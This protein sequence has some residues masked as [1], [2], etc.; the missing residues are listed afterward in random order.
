MK[1]LSFSADGSLTGVDSAPLPKKRGMH[2][3]PTQIRRATDAPPPEKEILR[4]SQD[5]DFLQQEEETLDVYEDSFWSLHKKD[6]TLLEPLPFSN[7]KTQRDVV[8]Q[9]VEHIQHG[10]KVI[11]IHGVCGTGKS[12]IALNIARALNGKAGIVVPI[13]TLQKQYEHDYVHNTFVRKL[14]GQKMKIAMITGRDNHDSIIEPGVSCADPN[15]PDTIKLTDRNMEKLKDY[16]LKNPFTNSKN[17]PSLKHM[18]RISV[19]PANPHWSPIMPAEIELNVLKDATKRKYMGMYGREFVFYHRKPGC[20]YYD[21]YLAY[22][23]AD[24]IIYNAAKYLAESA[25]GR[26][27]QTTVDI[28]DEADEFLDSLSNQKALNLTRLD[29]ALRM[30]VPDSEQ[31]KESIRKI[32][33]FIDAQLTRVRAL[34]IDE[35]Q[36]VPIHETP[37]IEILELVNDDSELQSEIAIDE[38]NYANNLVEAAENFKDALRDTYCLFRKDDQNVFAELVTTNLAQKFNTLVDGN[39]AL[40]LMSGTLHSPAVLEHIFGIE[41][42]TIVEAETLNQGS[43][44]IHRVGKEFDCRYSNFASKQFSR[45]DYLNALRTV[46]NRSTKPALVHVN[47]F[48]D[49]PNQEETMMFNMQ[50]VIEREE[51]RQKQFTDKIG[52]RVTDFKEG[53]HDVLFTTKAARGIDFPGDTCKSVIFTKYPN[54]NVKDLFFQ[55]LQKT[56]PDYYW[57][58][59]RDKAWREFL[60]RLYRAV[61][62]RNDHVYVLSPDTR[63]LEA[64]RTLQTTGGQ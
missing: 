61:R 6:G 13:K 14:N 48:S 49:L 20:S 47:A 29:N 5:L 1:R 56:H 55:I 16:Y 40:V 63:V 22:M 42:F 11:F 60:Q 64:V 12:A 34:G 33:N 15:L 58:F 21:Q 50:G 10:K 54:P 37:L 43:I 3:N 35:E 62:S 57:E 19:A 2:V 39:R 24:V 59:Y 53:L 23:D 26:K 52:K 8:E 51:L 36:I 32:L 17:P 38:M 28:I 30:L 41:D 9:V 4:T 31:A 44:E 45:H 18:K 27:P 7:G 46:V 25:M